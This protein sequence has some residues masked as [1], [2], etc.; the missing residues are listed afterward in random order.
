MDQTEL[1][2]QIS[3]RFWQL[4]TVLLF[5]LLFNH[6]YFILFYFFHLFAFW[7]KACFRFFKSV[8][9]SKE[10]IWKVGG[11]CLTPIKWFQQPCY[12]WFM[13][14][15]HG[16]TTCLNVVLSC[17]SLTKAKISCSLAVICLGNL[18]NKMRPLMALF[19]QA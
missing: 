6:Y 19:C 9:G 4:N 18:T 17:L 2:N 13:V 16:L 14:Y 15:K 8:G 7:W 1:L 5:L 11:T 12:I 10:M 3:N